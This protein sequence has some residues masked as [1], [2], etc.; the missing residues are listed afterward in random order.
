MFI[1]TKVKER[2][3]NNITKT[4]DKEYV[5]PIKKLKYNIEC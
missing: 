1:K 3:I 2:M 5:M 4:L